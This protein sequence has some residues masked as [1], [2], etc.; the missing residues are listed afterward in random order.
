[1][2]TK[3]KIAQE[4]WFMHQDKVHKGTIDKIEINEHGEIR[5][6][7]GGTYRLEERIGATQEELK[8]IVFNNTVIVK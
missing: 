4:V 2:K 7:V 5:Y 3:Y 6:R 8:E 1:M